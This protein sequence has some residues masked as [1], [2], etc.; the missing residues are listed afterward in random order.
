MSRGVAASGV[1]LDRTASAQ[2]LRVGLNFVWT[3]AEVSAN[4]EAEDR[5]KEEVGTFSSDALDMSSP[6][7]GRSSNAGEAVDFLS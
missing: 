6:S 7:G 5:G 3:D 1:P 4:E 2:V